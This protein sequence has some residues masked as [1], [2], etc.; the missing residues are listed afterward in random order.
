[1]KRSALRLGW[2]D[3]KQKAILLALR[4]FYRHL[5]RIGL[6]RSDDTEAYFDDAAASELVTFFMNGDGK[7]IVSNYQAPDG[8]TF[9]LMLVKVSDVGP[10]AEP[11]Q[12]HV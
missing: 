4:S 12:L 2:A 1:M 10:V 8:R 11:G 3:K 6:H 9:T 5:N 7:A